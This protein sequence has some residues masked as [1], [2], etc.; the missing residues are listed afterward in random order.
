MDKTKH[1]S[2]EKEKK[3]CEKNNAKIWIYVSIKE[4]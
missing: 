3:N 2:V 4:T 1:A